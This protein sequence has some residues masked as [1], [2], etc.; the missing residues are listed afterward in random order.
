MKT[1]Y[2]CLKC[3]G[4]D[5]V[6]DAVYSMNSGEFAHHDCITCQTCDY[7]SSS[8]NCNEHEVDD[9]FD[10]YTDTLPGTKETE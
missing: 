10:V 1:I 5:L 8:G 2:S 7:E 4:F 9:D 3:G 6:Q